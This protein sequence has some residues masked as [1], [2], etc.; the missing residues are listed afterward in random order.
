M[1]NA[2]MK[3]RVLE[4]LGDLLGGAAEKF[5]PAASNAKLAE[6]RLTYK[7]KDGGVLRC[8]LTVARAEGRSKT[9]LETVGEEIFWIPRGVEVEVPWYVIAQM[10]NN[11]ESKF[12][13]ERDPS[14]PRKLI[15]LK[16]EIPTESFNYREIDP[17]EGQDPI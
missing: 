9:H 1:A 6:K 4:A 14:D 12:R 7:N 15:T 10:K 3:D 11:V 2:S 16:D 13:Q 8:K 5:S 17:A